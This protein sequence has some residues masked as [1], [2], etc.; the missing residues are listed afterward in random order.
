MVT[1][2]PPSCLLRQDRGHG[3][4]VFFSLYHNSSPVTSIITSVHIRSG[5]SWHRHRSADFPVRSNPRPSHGSSKRL[6]PSCRSTLLRTGKSALRPGG[7]VEMRP[8]GCAPNRL[9]HV[10]PLPITDYALPITRH[11]SLFTLFTL[12]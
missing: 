11:Y 10:E 7:S 3:L 1:K 5:A 2:R 12:C 6:K 8:L 4:V 9:S